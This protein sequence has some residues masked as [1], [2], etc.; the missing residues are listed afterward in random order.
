MEQIAGN[1][2]ARI[3]ATL[4]GDRRHYPGK[5]DAR[6]S[7]E[8]HSIYERRFS[9][10]NAAYRR[11]VWQVFV[12]HYFQQFV[13]SRA[14]VLNLGCGCGE[15]IHSVVCGHKHAIDLN[16]K[17]RDYLNL[18]VQLHQCD[19]SQTW[20]LRDQCLDLVFTRNFFE[21]LPNKLA[22]KKTLIEAIVVSSPRALSLLWVPTFRS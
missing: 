11:R 3:P 8:L 16:P 7:R 10:D 17:S 13:P 21:H 18:D 20:P 6:R 1:S 19:C 9:P 22:L 15:F 14:T 2:G 5:T 4:A 12:R